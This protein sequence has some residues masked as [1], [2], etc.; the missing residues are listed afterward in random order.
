MDRE[1]GRRLLQ[2]R[3]LICALGGGDINKAAKYILWR[4][5]QTNRARLS[6]YPH[7]TQ[8]TDTSNVG[9]APTRRVSAFRVLTGADPAGLC[10]GQGDHLAECAARFR[11]P[12]EATAPTSRCL[13]FH[14]Q[15]ARVRLIFSG[16]AGENISLP[17]HTIF[18]T[19]KPRLYHISTSKRYIPSCPSAKLSNLETPP[20][21]SPINYP[22]IYER[23][24]PSM[25]L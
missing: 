10:C 7:L 17:K 11:H 6:V 22:P 14:L 3:V 2:D 24:T 21:V 18:P 13:P 16:I 19:R 9:C 20:S 8:A 5:T 25:G 15:N 12:L 1:L 4:F 23:P